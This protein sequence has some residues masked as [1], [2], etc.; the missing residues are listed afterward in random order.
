MIEGLF[1]SLPGGVP[2]TPD[3]QAII[4]PETLAEA[5]KMFYYLTRCPNFYK[6]APDLY[7]LFSQL[8]NSSFPFK[9]VMVTLTRMM[10]TA[11]EKKREIELFATMKG[12]I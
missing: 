9:T 2:D 3:Y 4:T 5:Q 10:V 6:T 11:L 1:S 8:I 7:N 12:A